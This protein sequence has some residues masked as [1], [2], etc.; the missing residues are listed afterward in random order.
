M[1]AIYNFFQTN[2]VIVYFIYPLI[3][4]LMGFG[5]L[6]K[7]TAHSRFN[8]AQSLNYLGFFGIIQGISDWG[9]IFIPIQ[10]TYLNPSFIFLLGSIKTIASAISFYFLFYFGMHLL[11]NTREGSRKYLLIPLFLLLVWFTHFI[12]LQPFLV[13]DKNH[14]WW[15]A[16]SDIWSRYLLAF[17]G[18]IVSSYALFL[19]RREFQRFG[20]PSM[21]R[22]LNFVIFSMVLYSIVGGIIV[23]YAPVIPALLFNSKLFFETTGIPVELFR[24]ISGFLMAFFTLKILKV[25]D[26]EYQNYFYQAER[27]KAVMKERDMIA[28]DLHDGIIQS[29][30]GIGLYLEKIRSTLIDQNKDVKKVQKEFQEVI[31]NLNA[32]IYDIRSYIKHLKTPKNVHHSLK[33]VINRLIEELNINE[34]LQLEFQYEYA[35]KEL[36]IFKT[37]QIYYIL[38]EAFSNIL[39]HADATKASL[40]VIGN[41]ENLLIEIIDNGKGIENV[42][43][44]FEKKDNYFLQ[45]GLRNMKHRAESIGGEL[46]I[47]STLGNGVKITLLLQKGREN[48]KGGS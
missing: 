45:Q 10:Q 29:I 25:F 22:T 11:V 15:L 47:V 16:I 3:F 6:L 46:T 26:I 1:S 21:T 37:V 38:K 35:G 23:P 34:Y 33:E 36:S 14:D 48:Q 2:I 39:R 41:N 43:S 28:R 27:Q 7:N 5:I 12:F 32:I 17:P 31:T 18:G 8:L 30:Y 20:V 9:K 4:F 40:K 44:H 42:N 19:Q 24:G 13:N